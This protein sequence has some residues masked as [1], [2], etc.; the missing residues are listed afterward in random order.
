MK[1]KLILLV[2]CVMLLPAELS[3][4]ESCSS[5][6][7]GRYRWA[8]HDMNRPRPPVVT[9]A[10]QPG[11]PP[12]NAIVLFDGRDLSQWVSEKDG[13]PAK[14]KVKNEY[15]EVVKKTGDIRTKRSFGDCQLH[16]EWA[17]PAKGSGIGQHH[18]NS[19]VFLMGKYEVQI[20]NSYE[21]ETYADGQA[22]AMYGQYPPIVNACL[23]P[24]RWQSYDI[25]FRRPRFNKGGRVIR[26]ARITVLHNGV[27]VHDNA[28]LHGATVHKKRAK[29]EA[30][31]DKLP[32]KLQDHDDPVRYRNIWL[33]ELPEKSAL[34]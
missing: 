10:E 4:Y 3:C 6:E 25:I 34:Y 27:L 18:G 28:K 17:C 29:Y 5:T 23:P 15:M 16:V 33:V 19:G 1:V 11:Q 14:W 20:V 30:H 31:A 7:K 21:N 22:A 9:P 12:S 2:I 8:V 13:R 26:P 32:L 24:G